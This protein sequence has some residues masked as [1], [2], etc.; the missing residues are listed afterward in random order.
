MFILHN[1]LLKF[2]SSWK[3]NAL[4]DNMASFLVGDDMNMFSNDGM[5]HK[6]SNMV[7]ALLEEKTIETYFSSLC[8]EMYM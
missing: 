3:V 2:K 5:G 8:K 7:M 1:I 4:L 6:Y